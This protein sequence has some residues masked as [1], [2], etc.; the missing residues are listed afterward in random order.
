MTAFAAHLFFGSIIFAAEEETANRIV[1]RDNFHDETHD[2]SGIVMVPS[3]CH[4]L[5]VRTKDFDANTTFIIFE[6]WE[7]T[8]R[9]DCEKTATP[10]AI[11]VSVFAP[12]NIQFKGIFDNEV[13]PITVIESK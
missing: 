13:V 9:T 6:T 7:Q 5:S 11:T 10:R 8:Y 12:K 2:L 4:D 3:T 1:M